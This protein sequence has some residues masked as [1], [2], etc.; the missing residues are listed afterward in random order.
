[1]DHA[2]RVIAATILVTATVSLAAPPDLSKPLPGRLRGGYMSA[3]NLKLLPKMAALGMNAAIPKFGAIQAP[4]RPQDAEKLAQWADECGRLNLAFMPVF[5]W[6]GGHEPSW[7]KDFNRVVTQTGRTLAKTPCPYTE[8]FWAKYIT[9][10]FVA[11]AEAV[12]RR[13]LAGICLDMEMY[14][15]ESSGYYQGCYC[16]ECF[17]RYLRAKGREAKLPPADKRGEAIKSAGEVKD[18]QA[19]QREVA[20]KHATACREAIHKARSGLR[21]GVLHLDWPSPIQEGEALG[22]GTKELPVFCLTERMYSN[23]FT[24]YIAEAQKTFRDLGA[25]VDLLVGLWHS[26]FPSDNIPEQ[27]YH[28]GRDSYGYWI[29][30]METFEQ[31][32]YSPLPGRPEAHWAAIQRANQEL[33]KLAAHARYQTA[34]TIRESETP[35]PPVSIF[36]FVKYDL[37]PFAAQK[38][39]ALPVARLRG[40]NWCYFHAKSGD[41]IDLQVTW[42]QV[43]RYRDLARAALVSPQGQKLVE[44]DVKKDA[45]GVIQMDAAQP[46]V[47][48][49]VVQAGANA[50]EITKA[51]HPYAIHIASKFGAKLV[52][53]V[54]TLCIAME[55]GAAQA[56]L[57]LST[58]G[59]AEAVKGIVLAEDG[60]ELWS[61]VVDGMVKVTLEKPTGAYLQLKFEKLPEHVLEDIGVKAVKGVLPFAATAPAALLK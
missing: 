60:K 3:G 59:G 14:G 38:P 25:H 44:V 23:G 47:Y 58:E 22:F 54:P 34:M 39:D 21:I 16:D 17:T 20:R 52:T 27:L 2:Y 49:L 36:G 15:A 26:K 10:R 46:G 30:T 6:W 41:K 53:K 28:C 40:G 18:Y 5:N 12:G 45:P 8:A 51:A 48:G 13:P 9:A 37:I 32:E 7:I 61:G 42:A 24:P 55:A 4:M 31:P 43:G 29:Y 56:I 19:L 11:M 35:V 1:M 57:E 50:V 33:D